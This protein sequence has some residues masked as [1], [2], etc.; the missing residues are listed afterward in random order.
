MRNITR[1]TI[2]ALVATSIA[3]PAAATQQSYNGTWP[4]TIR[5][6]QFFTGTG[7]LTL[8]GPERHGA[9]TLVLNGQTY[10]Y[11]SFLVGDGIFIASIVKPSGSQNGVLQFTAHAGGGRIGSGVFQDLE[12]G[13]QLDGGALTVGMKNGC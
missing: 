5:R 6:S 1:G 4:L 3:V 11:G 12:G 8:N 7:C 10:Q 2:L 9:A 13:S